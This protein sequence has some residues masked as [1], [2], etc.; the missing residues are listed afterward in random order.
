MITSKL[1]QIYKKCWHL[2]TSDPTVGPFVPLFPMITYRWAASVG[3]RLVQS[4]FRSSM[5]G[6][7]CKVVGTFPCGSC[8]YCKYMNTRKNIYLPNGRPFKAKHYS[9]CQTTGVVYLILCSCNCFYIGKTIQKL[10]QR[11][12]RHIKS[13][14]TANPDLPLGRHVAQTH[15]GVCPTI[16]VLALDRLHQSPQGGDYDKYLLQCELRWI[17][18][19]NATSPPGLNEALNFK[20]FLPG[21]VTGKF[22]KD[23]WDF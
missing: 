23:Q 2:L 12:Y 17:S 14:E 9:N 15:N 13:M 4:E 6:D 16:S 22:D 7:P 10:W 8:S 18:N 20:P 21:F 3:D 19:L 5:R 1:T 11:L